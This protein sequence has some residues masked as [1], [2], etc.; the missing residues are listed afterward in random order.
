[1][2]NSALL[3][4]NLIRQLYAIVAE[5]ESL[6]PGR[7]F[8]LDGH[9]VGS[10]GEVLAAAR[11]DLVLAPASSEGHD[12]KTQDGR[13]VEVKATQANSV[14]LR[15]E[16]QHLIVLQILPDGQAV[17]VYNGPGLLPWTQA[18]RLQSNGQR[19]ISLGRLGKLMDEV[20]QQSQLRRR[21]AHL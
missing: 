14:G 9:I 5:L 18:G 21:A 13:L 3:V 20:S 4:P 10:I 6:F 11:Y 2:D 1:V 15:S 19:N 12:A 17:E 7:H 16:P 8:T